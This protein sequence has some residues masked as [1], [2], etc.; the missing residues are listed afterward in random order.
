M[1][2]VV[3]F[4][5]KIP[6]VIF[7][8]ECGYQKIEY[9]NMKL[10]MLFFF[11]CSFKTFFFITYPFFRSVL[12][13]VFALYFRSFL[14]MNLLMDFVVAILFYVCFTFFFFS[15]VFPL[16]NNVLAIFSRCLIFVTYNLIVK[17][18]TSIFKFQN[19]YSFRCCWLEWVIQLHITALGSAENIVWISTK[20][21][22][23]QVFSPALAG[24][25]WPHSLYTIGRVARNG[26]PSLRVCVKNS[27]NG[28]LLPLKSD[29]QN[30]LYRGRKWL[31][32]LCVDLQAYMLFDR[33]IYSF[34]LDYSGFKPKQFVILFTQKN[35]CSY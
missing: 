4:T 31:L 9:E 17:P 8:F 3:K 34:Q 27:A 6:F 14:F 30:R 13:H 7:R 28:V 11:L 24:W 19:K 20:R 32:S 33:I 1:Q 15:C 23:V 18:E 2:C 22:S 5:V 26:R 29:A 10:I 21:K 25:R 35:Y 12:C 16:F